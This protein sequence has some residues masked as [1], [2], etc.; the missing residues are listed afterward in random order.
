MAEITIFTAPKPFTNPH[1]ALIQRNAIRS[2]LNLGPQV[3]VIVI[4]EEEGLAEAAAEVGVCHLRQVA[5]SGSGTPLVSAM[6]ELARQNSA[7]PLLACVNADILLMP[8]FVE[9]A[10]AAARQ[11]SK[12]LI[13]GQRWDLDVREPL[14]FAPGW[15][16]RL[17]Q[18]AQ[19]Q[20]KLHRASGSD[21]F[22]FPR[23]C[24]QDMPSFTIGRAGWDNWMIY[25][26][27]RSGW[28]VI[29][30][31]PSIM[32]IHQNHDYSH[33]PGGQPHY[34]HPETF[35]NIRLA[36]GKRVIFELQDV[37]RRLVGEHLQS[38]PFS[39]SKLKREAEIFPL[40]RLKSY[41]LGQLTYA[42]FHPR[43]AYAE[44]RQALAKK[45]TPAG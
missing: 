20:G 24:F 9:A 6:F 17:R 33:L 28:P 16:E 31:T 18:Q 36:G 41:R 13:V 26:G 14:S 35:E 21:Y 42:L 44:L 23:A 37:N 39:W 25:A 8:D 34:R 30:G 38:L 40:I 7:S 27:R 32:I 45:T 4:G 43:K 10:L 29:D 22:I 15:P 5:R 3:E 2:W 19:T 1:I 11:A 12:F